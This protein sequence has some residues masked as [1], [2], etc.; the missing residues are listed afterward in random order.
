[1][2]PTMVNSLAIIILSVSVLVSQVTFIRHL[3]NHR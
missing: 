3:R 2:T 1:V